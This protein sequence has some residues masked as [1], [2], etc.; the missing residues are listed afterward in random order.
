MVYITGTADLQL[1]L[2]IN[3]IRL[4]RQYEQEVVVIFVVAII[5]C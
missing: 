5:M 4:V 3:I 2:T 1:A